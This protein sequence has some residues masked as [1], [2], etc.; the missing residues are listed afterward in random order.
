MKTFKRVISLGTITAIGFSLLS[1]VPARAVPIT[2]VLTMTTPAVTVPISTV[3][4]S[5]FG[6]TAT[7]GD[8][9]DTITYSYA[10]TTNPGTNLAK[11]G[12]TSTAA[13]PA[14]GVAK[15]ISGASVAV[16]GY[17][18][19]L[20]NA[21]DNLLDT[22]TLAGAAAI[23]VRSVRGAIAV[24][25]T[26]VG[27]YVITVTATS[28]GGNV[29]AAT[30]TINAVAANTGSFTVSK[31]SA[32]GGVVACA[33]SLTSNASTTITAGGGVC[34]SDILTP[35]GTGVW[36]SGVSGYF[37]AITTNTTALGGTGATLAAA[38]P[39]Q[40]DIAP[41]A[42]LT[43]KVAST[44]VASGVI[45]STISGMTVAAG[46]NGLLLLNIN[47]ALG[48]TAAT[49]RMTIGGALISSAAATVRV[50]DSKMVVPF[51]APVVAGTYAVSVQ[52]SIGG[53]YTGTGAD[54]F[55]QPFTLT[56]TALSGLS[57][58]TS[59]A[60]IR[61]D[62]T[63]AVA[64]SATDAI[65]VTSSATAST[66][67]SASMT[68]SLRD[69]AAVAMTAGNTL[70]ATV[71][72][73]GYIRWV[74]GDDVPQAS[75]CVATPTFGALLGRSV[76]A[77]ATDAVGTLYVCADGTAGKST[78]VITIADAAG[79]SQALST[80][81]LTF[82]GAVTKLAATPVLTIGTAGGATTG[83]AAADRATAAVIPAVI[84]KATDK[85]GVVV[86]GLTITGLSSN[87]AAVN[88][89]ITVNADLSTAAFTSGGAGFYNT[90]Y[91]TTAV[92]KSGDKA[93][94]T[95]RTVDPADATK[96]ISVDVALTVG[97][98][99]ATEV[100]SFDK[101][102][103]APGEAMV[104]TI[105][106]KDSAGNPV[107]DGTASPAITFSKAVGGATPLASVYVG[108]KK[109]TSATAPT[110]FAP[111]IPGAFSAL[112]TS[113]NAAATALTA[114]ATVADANAGLLT[115]IDALN[116]K[117]VALNA[118]IAK[119]MKKLGVK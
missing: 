16:A 36:A 97:G 1:I 20:P 12:L 29:S 2:T 18:Q 87:L 98:S 53:T 37:G 73:P 61:G 38:S 81:T 79:V 69:A 112:A 78:V 54:T 11:F 109:A 35:A 92:S 105:T 94:L 47:G 48:N 93:T 83:N 82:F 99:V 90:S 46:A 60:L 67:N 108:G 71:T 24:Q 72:G 119:I 58:G 13:A 22:F 5:T 102:S 96:F 75:Q 25:P 56:V 45:A 4:Q 74:N 95:F 114:A 106:A 30:F 80:K 84:I 41:V 104:V 33:N 32:S 42:F 118:L 27:T 10:L 117:I 110:V 66:A 64:T 101:T 15:L 3:A 86:A 116:A 50:G 76:T 49:G 89:T 6:I 19:T 39:E 59:T 26:A 70:S 100:L 17:V 103:Y 91:S 14:A 44:T 43:G 28:T 107:A 52:V 85:D 77:Q 9:A 51:T 55:T 111:T 62:N 65:A 88:S 34:F 113:T 40:L 63:A 115:Q 8:N 31:D 7:L 57:A 21:G 68:I 23:A